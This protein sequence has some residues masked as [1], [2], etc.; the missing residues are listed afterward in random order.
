MGHF[1]SNLFFTFKGFLQLQILY[2]SSNMIVCSI[3]S[4][5][6][7]IIGLF[8]SRE[9]GSSDHGCQVWR[10]MS[11]LIW[12]I[13]YVETVQCLMAR[14]STDLAWGPIVRHIISSIVEI[15]FGVEITICAP[16]IRLVVKFCA[17]LIRLIVDFL[18]PIRFSLM[19]VGTCWFW[20][21]RIEGKISWFRWW[22]CLLAISKEN[23]IVE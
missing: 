19:I 13:H 23:F 21:M 10:W 4:I 8:S 11:S 17:P 1:I 15:I 20:L 6:G 12:W 2:C 5:P 18:M 22:W 14:L 3:V 7:L 16:L 9:L